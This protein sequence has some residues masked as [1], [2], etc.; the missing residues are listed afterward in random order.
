[1]AL[2]PT[3]TL[4]GN[5]SGTWVYSGGNITN[6]EAW[7]V[8]ISA[9]TSGATISNIISYINPT[10]YQVTVSVIGPGA[11]SFQLNSNQV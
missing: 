11:I 2:F 7:A 10:R 1:M 5:T 8:Q 4:N 9:G 6:H 3:Q